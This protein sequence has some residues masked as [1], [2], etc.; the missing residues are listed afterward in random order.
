MK[1]ALRRRP[2]EHLH[3]AWRLTSRVGLHEVAIVVVSFLVYFL[4]RGAVVGRADEAIG[5]ARDLISME[6]SLGLYV[7][8]DFQS[9]IAGHYWAIKAV[10]WVYF[11]GHMPLIIIAA[12]WLYTTHRRE[13][14]LTRNAFLVSGAIGVLLYAFF[15]VAP[16]RLIPGAGFI[17]TMAIY[18]KVG[19]NAQ[20]TAA[21]VNPYA[22]LPSLHF[23]WALLLGVLVAH[24]GR[25]P[26]FWVLAVAWPAAMLLSIVMTGNHFIIDAAAGGAVSFAGLGIALGYERWRPKVVARARA[27]ISR[28]APSPDRNRQ[29]V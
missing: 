18:D 22:A 12:V 2:V 25:R 26:A 8:L 14:L 11:W 24:A 28:P 10:N 19:Y 23:G 1:A 29:G 17:D 16:P 9:W 6:R 7:E 15:P 13:Y 5:R 20:E 4:I 21:F 3:G 27:V